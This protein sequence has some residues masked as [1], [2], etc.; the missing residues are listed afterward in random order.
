MHRTKKTMQRTNQQP[1]STVRFIT[2]V[3]QRKISKSNSLSNIK[4]SIPEGLAAVLWSALSRLMATQPLQIAF[5]V[6]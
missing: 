4:Q 6:N 3:F 5:L 1:T 2:E